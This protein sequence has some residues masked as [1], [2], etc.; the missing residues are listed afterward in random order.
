MKKKVIF[1]LILGLFVE[2]IFSLTIKIG[3]IAPARS[4]WDKA[5]RELSREW[6]RISNGKIRIKIYPG[7]IAGSEKAMIKKMKIG[8]LGGAVFTNRGITSIYPDFYVLSIPLLIQSDEEL[9]YVTG[10]MDSYFEKKI[11]ERGYKVLI[12]SMA[13]WVQFFSKNPVFKPADLKKH[14]LSFATGEPKMEQAW[15]RSGYQVIPNELKDL[16][17][18]LQSGMVNAFYLPALVAASGQY[19]ALAPNLASVKVAPLYGGIVLSNRVWKRI[20]D[21]IKPEL[22]SAGKKLSKKLYLETKSLEKDAIKT[23]VKNGLKINEIDK[24]T[25]EQWHSE[26]DKTVKY[27]IGKSFSREIYDKIKIYLNEFRKKNAD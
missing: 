17:M 6:K 1:I 8:T 15:K 21:N 7:G 19:F 26:A 4:P 2:T 25:M 12:W 18:A 27:L 9:M 20:P 10:K 5:L 22:L 14:K 16:M 3:S 11:E 13:G 24:K 23:M